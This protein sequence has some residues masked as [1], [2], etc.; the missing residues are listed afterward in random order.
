MEA[1]ATWTSTVRDTAAGGLHRLRA[2]WLR[3]IEAT[4]GASMAWLVAVELLHHPQPFFAP[5]S[6]LIVLGVTLG[7]RWQRAVEIV[8]GVAVGVLLADI[9]TRAIGPHTIGALIVVLVLTLTVA[10]VLGGGPI[11]AVQATVSAVYV[12]TVAPDSSVVGF[13]R[14]EDALVGG[15]VA[16]VINLLPLHRDPL[17]QVLHDAGA[18]LETLSG[19]LVDT[20][21][22]LDRHDRDDAEAA[23]EKARATD[24]AVDAFRASVGV[25]NDVSRIEPWRRRRSDVLRNY[26]EMLRQVDYAVRNV[27]VLSRAVVAVTRSPDTAPPGLGDA[28]REL[29][30]AVTALAV[31]LEETG[32]AR[33]VGRSRDRAALAAASTAEHDRLVLER[34]LA[35]VRCAAAVQAPGVPLAVL[36]IVWQV[37]ST[38]VDLLRGTGLDLATVLELTDQALGEH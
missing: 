28:I 16:L 3:V 4:V 19:V 37:R 27:R 18:V 13:G 9:I 14:F 5:A 15:T 25:G 7:R 21:A 23:L 20:A 22:A 6:A 8:V 35:A 31:D 2:D 33:P 12:A 10:V 1:V 38:A 17:R 24:A 26:Q 29:A 32:E 11:L 30:G 34:A 36:G